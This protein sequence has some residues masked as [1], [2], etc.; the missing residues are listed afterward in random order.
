MVEVDRVPW[1]TYPQEWPVVML[2]EAG[3]TIARLGG[4]LARHGL[5]LQ[6]AHPWNVLFD[7]TRPV[8]VDLGSITGSP[9]VAWVWV[10]EFRTS[11][12]L[13][14]A[15]HGLGRHAIA[16]A[17]QGVERG[18]WPKRLAARRLQWFPFGY[19]LVKLRRGRPEAFFAALE[20]YLV[21]LGRK[22]AKTAWRYYYQKGE[23]A[24][25]DDPDQYTAKQQSVAAALESIPAGRLLD[26]GANAGWYSRL[27]ALLGHSVVAIDLDDRVLGDLYR[28][29]TADALPI[30]P[31]R[32]DLMWPTGSSGFGLEQ[33]AAPDRLKADTVLVLAL[34]HHLLEHQRVTF[35]AFAAV[36]ALFATGR[37][38]VEFVGADDVHLKGWWIAGEPWYTQAG[39]VEAMSPWFRLI[40][41]LPS[42]PDTRTILVFERLGTG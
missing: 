31:L 40:L 38:I 1:V 33:R 14:L 28:R 7:G 23:L 5:G 6:D 37:A 19:R 22:G 4:V 34:L 21:G 36:L 27:A 2:R 12:V 18:W 39:F 42:D 17:V 10:E 24:M 13:P 32:M 20:R 30:V 9:E 25:V 29:S 35:E 16:E 11:V 3:L 8:F 15:L 26:V 41:I